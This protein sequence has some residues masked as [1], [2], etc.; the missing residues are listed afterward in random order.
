[1][2]RDKNTNCYASLY[3]LYDCMNTHTHTHADLSISHSKL[4]S[5]FIIYFERKIIIN[6]TISYIMLKKLKQIH[7]HIHMNERTNEWTGN[8]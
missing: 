8:R 3:E 2:Y 4:K 5:I 1:M 7:T 6:F